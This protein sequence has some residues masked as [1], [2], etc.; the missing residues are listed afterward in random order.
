VTAR[1]LERSQLEVQLEEAPHVG[2]LDR[3]AKRGR[4]RVGVDRDARPALA[5]RL[6]GIDPDEAGPRA[7]DAA[8][9]LGLELRLCV[10]RG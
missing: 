5:P 2:V 7:A 3:L 9:E 8:R 4:R 10:R 1:A 6:V